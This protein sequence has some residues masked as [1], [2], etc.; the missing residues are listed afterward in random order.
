MNSLYDNLKSQIYNLNNLGFNY[1]LEENINNL[2]RDEIYSLLEYTHKNY[3]QINQ[4]ERIIQN[5]IEMYTVFKYCYELYIIDFHESII[6]FLK[7]IYPELDI[8][9]QS[10]TDLRGDLFKFINM[11]V[12][13]LSRLPELKQEKMKYLFYLDLFDNNL[14]KFCVNYLTPIL[15]NY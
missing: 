7:V 12:N 5:D 8:T 11:R 10:L 9:C 2:D 4:F 14:E 15:S 6:P 13:N 1:L 3:L